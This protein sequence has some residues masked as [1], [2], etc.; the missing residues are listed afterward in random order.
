MVAQ[1]VRLVIM[2]LLVRQ[3]Q[4]AVVVELAHLRREAL[5]LEDQAAP[6]L[7]S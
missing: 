7:L 5:K 3:H 2:V 4:A 1:V 6:A